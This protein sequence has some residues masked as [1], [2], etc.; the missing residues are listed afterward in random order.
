MRI[1]G[2]FCFLLVFVRVVA[3]EMKGRGGVGFFFD[4]VEEGLGSRGHF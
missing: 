3:L 2:V 1:R 4:A